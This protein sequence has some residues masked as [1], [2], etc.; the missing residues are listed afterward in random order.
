MRDCLVK[1]PSPGHSGGSVPNKHL[2]LSLVSVFFSIVSRVSFEYFFF[3]LNF[4]IIHFVPLGLSVLHLFQ[5]TCFAPLLDYPFCTFVELSVLHAFRN[6]RLAPLS[7]YPFCT[8]FGLSILHLFWITCFA[9]LSDCL[10][11]SPFGLPI[12]HLFWI[13]CFATLSDCLFCTLSDYPFCTPFGFS[14]LQLFQMIRFAPYSDYLGFFVC[15]GSPL[16]CYQMLL[17]LLLLCFICYMV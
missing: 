5:N 9:P 2:K 6:I 17:F 1:S 12:L 15:L 14:F 4:R 16:R 10:F 3:A 13:T 7:D 11:C 8:S